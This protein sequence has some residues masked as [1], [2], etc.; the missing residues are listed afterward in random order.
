MG[1]AGKSITCIAGHSA[2]EVDGSDTSYMPPVPDEGPFGPE[3]P[4]SS[5]VPD[6]PDWPNWPNTFHW[7]GSG[8]GPY[9]FWQFGFSDKGLDDGWVVNESFADGVY[10]GADIEVW[11]STA[12]QATKFY[13][14]TC[15]WEWIG[16]KEYGRQPCV[17]LQLNTYGT[18]GVW[19]LATADAKTRAPDE[20]FCVIPVLQVIRVLLGLEL[21]TANLWKTRNILERRIF[22]DVITLAVRSFTYCQ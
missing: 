12:L 11:H 20:K 18:T 2:A 9:P 19:Y 5:A 17:A 21:S 3:G 8:Y 1:Y 6:A 7:K 10:D 22:V 16:F 14:D 15:R 13:H 4:G